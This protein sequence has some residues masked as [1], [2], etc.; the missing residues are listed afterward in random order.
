[1]SGIVV[2]NSIISVSPEIKAE[3]RANANREFVQAVGN[4]AGRVNGYQADLTGLLASA[5]TNSSALKRVP[6]GAEVVSAYV[7]DAKRRIEAAVAGRPNGVAQF[8]RETTAE[9][10][11]AELDGSRPASFTKTKADAIWSA[12]AKGVVIQS[13]AKVPSNVV[14]IKAGFIPQPVG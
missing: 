1:M 10:I 6:A 12:A 9:K 2:K 11:V 7:Q 4:F 14:A 13:S 5:W 3:H 8:I